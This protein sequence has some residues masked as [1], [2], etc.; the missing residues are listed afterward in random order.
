MQISMR[1]VV[2][3][4]ILLLIPAS[5]AEQGPNWTVEV[6]DP[7]GNPINDCDI[8]IVDPW[9]GA[10]LNQPKGGMFL[11]TATCEGYVVMWHPPVP[12]SQTTVVLDAYPIIDNLFSVEGVHTITVLGSDWQASVSDGLVDAPSGVELILL[13]DG[14]SYQRYNE[15]HILIPNATETYDLS[16]NYSDSVTVIAVHKMTGHIVSWINQSLTVGEFNGGWEARVLMDGYPVGQTTWPPNTSWVNQQLNSSQPVG[17]AVLSL[18]SGLIPNSDVT[19]KWSAN[20]VFNKGLGLPFIP[21]V[22]AGIES[23]VERFLDGDVNNLNTLLET[24]IYLNG[25]DANCCIIDDND[26]SFNNISITSDINISHYSWGWNE[27]ADVSSSRSHIELMRLEVPFQNDLRQSTPLK[28]KTGGEYQYLSSPLNEWIS[29][30]ANEFSLAR[31]LSSVSG[32]YT[33]SL[34]LNSP[35]QLSMIESNALPWENTSYDF[36]V[37]INDAPLS[38]HECEWNI[39]G[40]NISK[41]INLSSFEPDSLLDV[42]VQ[43]IDEGGLVSIL[44]RSFILDDDSPMIH[45]TDDNFEISPGVFHLDLNVSDDHDTALEIVWTSNKSQDWYHTGANLTTQ[46][47]VDSKL[48]SISDNITERHKQRNE[49][50]YW[51]MAN[52]TDD[53]GHKTSKTWNVSLK[54]NAPPVVI[55]KLLKKR[56]NEDLTEIGYDGSGVDNSVFQTTGWEEVNSPARLGDR[57]KLDLTESYDDHDSID[58]IKFAIEFLGTNV[59]NI[60]WD[61]AQFYE[62]PNPGIGS[63]PLR[64][65]TVD[66]KGN[67]ASFLQSIAIAPPI[68]RDLEIIGIMA[69]SEDVS[70]GKNQ[71]WITVQNNG[72]TDTEFMLCTKYECVSSIVESSNYQKTSTKLVLIEDDLDWFDSFSVDLSYIDDSNQTVIKHSSSNYESGIGL[73]FF[74]LF[75]IVVVAACGILWLRSRDKPRF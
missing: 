6:E 57:I 44:N 5:W 12:S 46:F 41:G 68:Q 74:D 4:A 13:G 58:K 22:N 39:F 14:G 72:A 75:V 71:F 20:H 2:F 70:P 56:P 50:Q 26:V 55:S 29:G 8:N 61:N 17:N 27:T 40:D 49:I 48:N 19:G 18:E 10:E 53:V 59:S 65:T 35:P 32:F 15:N 52:V 16:G 62:L 33:I 1:R 42:S 36:E 47:N 7:F 25:K 73:D 31:N 69:V 63:H 34:G 45:N 66:T 21:G 24:V 11:P 3:L 51:L 9:T 67:S 37:T 38:K 64:I 43:C 28:I 54:D 60:S 23:Q 30:N